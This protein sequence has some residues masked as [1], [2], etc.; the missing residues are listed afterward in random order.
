MM[1]IDSA[2]MNYMIRMTHTMVYPWFMHGGEETDNNDYIRTVAEM[3]E[4]CLISNHIILI[5]FTEK[6][7]I[8]RT[9]N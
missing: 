6:I 4:S 5:F 9:T 1:R 3:M 8:I 7:S 2:W